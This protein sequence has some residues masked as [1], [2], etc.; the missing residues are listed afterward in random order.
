MARCIYCRSELNNN[1]P[2]DEMTRSREHIVPFAIGGSN[3]FSTFDVSKKYNNDYGRDI[4]AK[5][6]NLLPI[7]IKRQM[8][9]LV[10]QSGK[11]PPIVW[12]GKSIDNGAPATITIHDDWKVECEFDISTERFDK[13]T[14]EIFSVS[15]DAD[16]VKRILSGVLEKCR[17]Q[18]KRIYSSSGDEITRM[19]DFSKHYEIEESNNFGS[20]IVAFD[21]DVWTRGIFK[22]I[23]GLGHV[24]LGPAWTFSSDGGDRFRTVLAMDR[25]H[26]PVSSMRGFTTGELPNEIA[27]ALGIDDEVREKN[28]HT[29]AILP[30]ESQT[31][32]VVSLFG[33]KCVPEA[34]VGLGGESGKLAV[35]NE[36]M[37]RNATIGVRIDPSSRGTEW[38]RVEDVVNKCVDASAVL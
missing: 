26:W 11:V 37:N 25:Q 19:D 2:Q 6:I 23:L 18:G 22:M 9:H 5:F 31:V 14:H 34:L 29:L 3:E 35:V 13:Q 24:L 1:S 15:G 28:K 36:M 38:I 33:G 30:T 20:S 17:K 7:S 32:A 16:K 27:L 4:D 21:L 8:L 10:G 12:H